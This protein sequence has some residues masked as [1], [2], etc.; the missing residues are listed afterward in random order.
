MNTTPGYRPQP[1]HVMKFFFAGVIAS[2]LWI[3]AT[4]S[5]QAQGVA[6]YQPSI[7]TVQGVIPYIYTYALTV[8]SPGNVPTGQT[9]TVDMQKS[10]SAAAPGGLDTATALSFLSFAPSQLT[11]SGPNESKVVLVTLNVPAGMPDGEYK[12]KIL[13]AGFP[14]GT[15]NFGAFVNASVTKA[16]DLVSPPTVA[17]QAPYNQQVFGPYTPSQMVGLQI[18]LQFTATATNEN[19]VLSV[20]V[21]VAGAIVLPLDVTGLDTGSATATGLVNISQPGTY[22]VQARAANDG[23]TSAA[24]SEFTV[25]VNAPPPTVAILLPAADAVYTFNAG[26]TPPVIQ[27]SFAGNSVFGVIREMS[28]TLNNV[29][30]AYRATGLN[31]LSATGATPNL[32]LSVSG[33]YT[34]RVKARTDFG[35]S[36]EVA[37]S[38]TVNVI[39]P[40][41]SVVI[42]S[43]SAN[44]AVTLPVGQLVGNIPFQFTTTTSAGFTVGSV[45]AKLDGVPVS[46]GNPNTGGLT[47]VS[48]GTLANV[49][50]GPHTL[51]VTGVSVEVSVSASVNFTVVVVPP[52]PTIVINDPSAAVINLPVGVLTADIPFQFTTSTLAGFKIDTVSATLDNQ[53]VSPILSPNLG[54][55]NSVVSTG[56]LVGMGAGLHTLNVT[57]T[58]G[59]ASAST[60]FTFTVNVTLKADQTITFGALA[61]KTV[62]DAAF[63]LGATASSNLGVSYTSSN[64]AVATVSGSTVTVVGAGSTTITASQAGNANYNAAT[65]VGQ[66]LIVNKANQTI[67]FGALAAKTVGDAAF[68]LGATASSNLGV[69][70]TSSNSAVATV[71]GSTVTVVGAGSTTITASQAGNANYNAATP[72]GQ[73]LTVQLGSPP[74]STCGTALVRHAPKLNGNAGIN[75]SLQ[76]LLPESMALNGNAWISES[77]LV[78]G[79]PTIRLNGNPT[80]GSVI[81]GTGSASPSN[82]IIT[83]NGNPVVGHIVLRTNAVGIPVINTPPAPSGV[84]DVKLNKSSDNSGDF[85]TLRDL[86]VNGDI[87]RVAVPPGNYRDLTAN[88][89]SG[90]IL[91]VAGSRQ[92]SVYYVRNLKLSGNGDLKI[93]GPVILTVSDDVTFNGTAGSSD[94]PEWLVLN[95]YSGDLTLSGTAHVY[96][97]VLAPF[98]KVTLSGNST[99]RGGLISDELAING[100]GLLDLCSC[101]D[102]HDQDDDHHG[103]NDDRD[104]D[105]HGNNR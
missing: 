17:I 31:T 55:S 74:S 43:P 21:S 1:A 86:T 83:L 34:L 39:Q 4:P 20:D 22:V 105:H 70:Y 35:W 40:T 9:T 76:F 2:V 60:S 59:S 28:A 53:S 16:P 30:V 38:F 69:S 89:N 6:S 12:Y 64:S 37:S 63:A 26:T 29:P 54:V 98:G 100:N 91:G 75:G 46:V 84:R 80:Y 101:D 66:T 7:K 99:L 13:A 50:A 56:T 85:A 57:G 72:V 52:A 18:P 71:S 5:A 48:T 51:I 103:N 47:A 8:K 78:P 23:G 19:P 82:Y 94:H 79:K 42:D 49:G 67:T 27:F 36:D 95:L 96:G 33:L 62:G 73:T 88:G 44:A 45:S 68:A 87:G 93:V 25:T 92:P 14:Y 102:S 97:S 3:Q 10:L 61:A 81:D 24:T 104:D 90:F 77:L 41:P 11:Y 32:A 65:P 15:T 58:S